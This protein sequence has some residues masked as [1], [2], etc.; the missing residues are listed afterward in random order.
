MENTAL[1]NS[2]QLL[3]NRNG[4]E[5]LRE[6]SKWTKFIAIVGYVGVGLMVLGALFSISTGFSE[7]SG[8]YGLLGGG[9]VGVMYLLIAALY[10]FPVHYLYNFSLNMK[11]AIASGEENALEAGLRYLKSHYKF[12]GI[13]MIIMLSFYL[14]MLLFALTMGFAMFT[15]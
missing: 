10:F 11:R 3:V 14:L 9:A 4:I 1:P 15:S 5:F 7:L 13:L 6:T 8:I 2:D 12:L